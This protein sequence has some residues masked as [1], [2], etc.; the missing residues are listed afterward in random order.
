MVM[1][2][3]AKLVIG[4]FDS[5]PILQACVVQGQNS[6]LPNRRREFESLH[7][8][9][10]F[11]LLFPVLIYILIIMKILDRARNKI[12]AILRGL[13]DN[14]STLVLHASGKGSIPLVSTTLEREFA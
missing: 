10:N 6:G 3:S 9:Q 13:S 7:P 4:E 5:P 14:G 12:T 8:H 1:R 11:S 2:K